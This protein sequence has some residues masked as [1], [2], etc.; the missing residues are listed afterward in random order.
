MSNCAVGGAIEE[1]VS[2]CIVCNMVSLKVG[3]I[4]ASRM[5]MLAGEG[6]Y[7]GFGD[8]G[9]CELPRNSAASCGGVAL[10]DYE[11]LRAE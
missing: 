2:G 7:E 3:S 5:G 1:K 4:W 10:M 9:V 6:K 8:T 11:E